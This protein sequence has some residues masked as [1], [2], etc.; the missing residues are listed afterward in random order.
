MSQAPQGQMVKGKVLFRRSILNEYS[1]YL[2]DY[3]GQNLLLMRTNR[4]LAATACFSIIGMNYDEPGNRV[5][6]ETICGTIESNMS[7]HKFKL[8]PNLSSLQSKIL[9]ISLKTSVG[10]PRRMIANASLCQ[11]ISM[12]SNENRITYILKNKQPTYDLSKKR[13]VLNYD[14]RARL[15]SKHNF[16]I[17]DE[18][19]PE[20]IIMQV[21]KLDTGE[22]SCDYSFPLCA[23]QAFALALSSFIR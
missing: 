1:F 16:Q 15:S 10:E 3:Y 21:G 9:E 4:K 12:A 5:L 23:L 14:G 2:E 20:V 6:Y 13:F 8:K 19:S 18:Y 22:F 7:R 11:G 17:V